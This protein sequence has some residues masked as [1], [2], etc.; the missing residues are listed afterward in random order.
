MI[1]LNNLIEKEFL[2]SV[3]NQEQQ[4][5]KYFKFLSQEPIFDYSLAKKGPIKDD[6]L[7]QNEEEVDDDEDWDEDDDEDWDEDDDEDWDEDDDEDWD[8]D[9]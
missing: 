4:E 6:E 9:D 8:E 2:M 1:L 5:N 7:F 3:L